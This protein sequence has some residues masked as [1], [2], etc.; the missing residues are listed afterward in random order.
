MVAFNMPSLTTRLAPDS[1]TKASCVVSFALGARE[2][3]ALTHVLEVLLHAFMSVPLE[4]S[5]ARFPIEFPIAAF[6]PL[7]RL[8]A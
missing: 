8:L 1:G 3:L 5:L 6:Q 7:D 2:A 4:L